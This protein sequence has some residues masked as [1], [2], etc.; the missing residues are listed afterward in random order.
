MVHMSK[1]GPFIWIESI[2]CKKF[3]KMCLGLYFFFCISMLVPVSLCSVLSFDNKAMANEFQIF[4]MKKKPM[5]K[6][7]KAYGR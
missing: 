6:H 7:K 4:K 2:C 3:R 5:K 1:I